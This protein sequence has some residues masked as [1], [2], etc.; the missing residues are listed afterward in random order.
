MARTPVR[1]GR[2]RARGSQVTGEQ[3]PHHTSRQVGK[4]RGAG[5]SEQLGA[6]ACRLSGGGAGGS[7]FQVE[8]PKSLEISF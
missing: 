6:L 8:A 4:E 5:E 3:R 7:C 1:G 2:A